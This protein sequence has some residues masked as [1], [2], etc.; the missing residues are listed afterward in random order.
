ME[1]LALKHLTIEYGSEES[2]KENARYDYIETIIRRVLVHIDFTT[3]YEA[4]IIDVIKNRK[5]FS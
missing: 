3:D 1:A 4:Q 2:I 5:F